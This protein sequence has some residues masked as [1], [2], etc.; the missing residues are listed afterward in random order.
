MEILWDSISSADP[1]G[2]TL[3]GCHPVPFFQSYLKA[4]YFCSGAGAPPALCSQ[5]GDLIPCSVL[6][7]GGCCGVQSKD[8]MIFARMK[9]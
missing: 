9:S 7:H 1:I 2:T 5:P 3:P 8:F 6:S 4:N